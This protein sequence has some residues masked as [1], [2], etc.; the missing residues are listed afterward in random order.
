VADHDH[1]HDGK[2]WVRSIP[3]DA[4]R[5]HVV[6]EIDADTSQALDGAKVWLHARAV[7][8]AVAQAEYDAAIMRQLGGTAADDEHAAR[9]VGHLRARRDLLAWPTPLALLP[10]VS[11]FTGEPFLHVRIRDRVVGQW[12]P[13]DARDHAMGVLEL[14]C[15]AGLDREY[16]S[17][18][19]EARVEDHKARVLVDNLAA[20]RHDRF[21]TGGAEG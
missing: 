12:T 1:D 2:V 20:H 3:D 5:Y 11:A 7:L 18:L 4:G 6:L 15:V 19:R 14:D 8:A 9:V 16:L 21:A 10:G 13:A 17:V